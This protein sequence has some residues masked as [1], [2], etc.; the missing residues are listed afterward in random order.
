LHFLREAKEENGKLTSK[1]LLWP[2]PRR[3][4]WSLKGGRI[5]QSDRP[6]KRSSIL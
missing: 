3:C 5:G 6:E 2:R 1:F 4:P